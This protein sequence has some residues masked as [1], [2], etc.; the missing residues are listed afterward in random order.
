MSCPSISLLIIRSDKKQFFFI[1]GSLQVVTSSLSGYTDKYEEIVK[2]G[3][4]SSWLG[5]I[6]NMVGTMFVQVRSIDFHL[7]NSFFNSFCLFL[8]LSSL[9]FLYFVFIFPCILLLFPYPSSFFCYPSFLSGPSLSSFLYY[10]FVFLFLLLSS[11]ILFLFSRTPPSL[12]P[13][14]NC[15]SPCPSSLF[16]YPPFFSPLSYFFFP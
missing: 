4:G 11:L 13:L 3:T 16:P 7:D 6:S 9:L 2:E 10:P 15:S 12:S 14:C 1:P 5:T 8:I